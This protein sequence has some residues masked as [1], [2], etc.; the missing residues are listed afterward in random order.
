MATAFPEKYKKYLDWNM[1]QIYPR[2]FN[3]SNGDGIGDIPGII[4]KL[5][6][7]KEL[8]INAIW[9]SPVFMS[10]GVDN[11]YD[12]SD[13]YA[14]NPEFGTMEDMDRLIAEAHKRDIKVLLDFVPNHT[15][16][17]HEWFKKSRNPSDPEFEKYKDFYYWYDEKPNNWW[18]TFGGEA[19]QFDETR[20]QYYL[21]SY[22]IEQ[23]DL[24]WDN[25]NVRSEMTKVVDF[26]VDK[27]IDGFRIDVIYQISKIIES[28]NGFGPHMHEY[29]RGLFGR[30]KTKDI[31]TVGE[32]WTSDV[33]AYIGMTGADRNELTSAF[34]FDI[35]YAD[36]MRAARDT[37]LKWQDLMSENGL[38][39]M[40]VTD[41]HDNV[42]RISRVG[43]DKE[44]RYESATCLATMMYTLKGMPL[45]YQGQEVGS[46]NPHYD[47]IDDFRDVDTL[48]KH[49]DNLDEANRISRDNARRPMTWTADKATNYGFTTGTPWITPHSRGDEI[50][51]ESDLASDKS[52]Y[53]FYQRLL[54]LRKDCPELRY[55]D[56]E[57]ISTD[58]NFVVFKR[59]YENKSVA[60][61]CNFDEASVIDVPISFGEL[62]LTNNADRTDSS[63]AYLPYEAA[64][65]RL[66]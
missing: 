48:N 20:G 39:H 22:A 3:D 27:G 54:K 35:M 40:L 65:Y 31:F 64:V 52:V 29:I 13:Y 24:N 17:E 38:L 34:Q 59:T 44:L 62:L 47:S 15:S 26:W 6:Y 37:M 4:E 9:L 42:R 49:R 50:N 10:P 55:G 63:C 28:S 2:S 25:P 19:W 1:Y 41:N 58:G 16:T 57:V 23:A 46:A 12:V 30:E 61:V 18:S 11:G 7:L 56:L 60:V 21:H 36:S 66:S 14:I 5:D 33:N 43:N 53:R 8:G 32:I 51:L 45:I